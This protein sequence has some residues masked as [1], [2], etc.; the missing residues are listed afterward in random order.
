[1]LEARSLSK[2]FPTPSGSLSVLSDVNLSVAGR[3]RVVVMGPSG[4]GKSTLLAILGGLEEPTSGNVQLDEVNPYALSRTR[5][6][7]F[8]N[9][10]V[11]FVFQ[12][13][14]LLESCTAL[15][16][17]LVPALAGGRVDDSLVQRGRFL[18]DRVGLGNRFSHL[19]AELSGGERQRVAVA[20]ALLLRPTMLLADEP[21]GQLDS[22]S[23]AYVI[24]LLTELVD[25]AGS[26]LCLVTHDESIAERVDGCPQG[27]RVHLFDGRL[28]A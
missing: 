21:T 24:D 22:I 23:A 6:A 27:R 2:S 15:D 28:V 8:R 14:C 3:E 20:R 26:L 4:S 13:H 9:Q 19:P 25:E 18:L 16:N 11:G 5:R 10:Q 12:D 1:M 17:V 7:R